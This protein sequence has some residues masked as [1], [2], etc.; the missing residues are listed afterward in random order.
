MLYQFQ[1][2]SEGTLFYYQHDG[3]P[4][5]D[6]IITCCPVCGEEIE[7]TGRTYPEI[8]ENYPLKEGQDG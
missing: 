7:R 2:L 3:S 6:H 8:D 5:P 4:F 1:C